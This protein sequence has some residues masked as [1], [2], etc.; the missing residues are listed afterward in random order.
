[1]PAAAY[2][3]CTKPWCAAAFRTVSFL[4]RRARRHRGASAGCETSGCSRWVGPWRDGASSRER[5]VGCQG[6]LH[7][8]PRRAL[9]R[10]T[11][12]RRSCVP[13]PLPLRAAHNRKGK[14]TA[15]ASSSPAGTRGLILLVT[16]VFLPLPLLPHLLLS[17]FAVA[18]SGGGAW[19]WGCACALA[20]VTMSA[21]AE[22]TAL[23]ACGPR[24]GRPPRF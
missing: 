9:Q 6:A 5:R 11:C 1:M 24:P 22:A 18:V 20:A 14:A 15:S 3:A 13:A 4:A 19:L 17:V 21:D 12:T 23:T 10:T 7:R 2:G 16:P 8:R